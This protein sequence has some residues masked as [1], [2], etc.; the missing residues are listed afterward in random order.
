MD[1]PDDDWYDFQT[2]KGHESTVWSLA[3]S[4]CGELLASASDDRTLR[5]WKRADKWRWEQAA[6]LTGHERSVYSVSWSKGLDPEKGE[7]GNKGWLAS[8][9][10][11]GK[12]NVWCILVR[13][14]R[15][16]SIHISLRL[17]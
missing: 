13:V 16:E 15:L 6:V 17:I 7:D 14:F 5:I 2:L 1:D 4:P 12:I 8:T 11:D 9:G 10:Q 3:F